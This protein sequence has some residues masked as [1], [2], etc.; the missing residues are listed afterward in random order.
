MRGPGRSSNTPRCIA[1]RRADLALGLVGVFAVR[2]GLTLGLAFAL[3]LVLAFGLD[4]TFAFAFAFAFAFTLAFTFA[5]VF[6]L[7]FVFGWVF[8]LA[9]VL[10]LAPV[11]ALGRA[12]A[13]PFEEAPRAFLELVDGFVGISIYIN[14]ISK[15]QQSCHSYK[16]K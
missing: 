2:L 4:L 16:L 11:F 10:A 14:Y 9:R 8:A 7:A 12:F 6:A 15:Q 1:G 3:G 5:L 13:E